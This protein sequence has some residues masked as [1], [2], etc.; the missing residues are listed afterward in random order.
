MI[1]FICPPVTSPFSPGIIFVWGCFISSVCLVVTVC[2]PTAV[3]W[4]LS[5]KKGKLFCCRFDFNQI[6]MQD[7]AREVLRVPNI[8][9]IFGLMQDI[10]LCLLTQKGGNEN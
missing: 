2:C 6:Q 3:T 1:R 8:P 10:L 5:R 4:I 9:Y 7:Y